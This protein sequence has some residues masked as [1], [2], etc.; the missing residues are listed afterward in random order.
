MRGNPC[1]SPFSTY[2]GFL[3]KKYLV[4]GSVKKPSGD[5][6]FTASNFSGK[7]SLPNI[8]VR[9]PSRFIQISIP[10]EEGR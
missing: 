1:S 5:F 6:H 2:H 10:P 3:L 4:P 7:A 8:L 9:E